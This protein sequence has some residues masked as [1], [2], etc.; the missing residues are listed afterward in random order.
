MNIQ[1]KHEAHKE[2]CTT[3]ALIFKDLNF[4]LN[5]LDMSKPTQ[6]ISFHMK[7]KT[8]EKLILDLYAVRPD[9]FER[10]DERENLILKEKVDQLE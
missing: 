1:V 10:L 5:S 6:E 9:L 3:I 4:D 2:S 8:L 7:D